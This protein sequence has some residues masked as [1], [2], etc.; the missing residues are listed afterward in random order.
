[1]SENTENHQAGIDPTIFNVNKTDYNN[2]PLFLGQLP[3]LHDSINRS[4]PGIHNL[5]K[6]LK[7]MDWD[8]LEFDFTPCKHE[9]AT[10]GTAADMMITSLSNARFST[11]SRISS[12]VSTC[13][14]ST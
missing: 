5:Y 6:K 4:D 3:G 12:A 10:G 9:F 1:M 7:N 14:V 2:T 13:T 11:C 8:E